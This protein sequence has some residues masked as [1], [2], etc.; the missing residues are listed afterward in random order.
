M[1]SRCGSFSFFRVYNDV[2][3]VFGNT[4]FYPFRAI[5]DFLLL[6]LHKEILAAGSVYRVT[7]TWT[8][9]PDTESAEC[10]VCGKT[11][12]KLAQF[13]QLAS[14]YR[15]AVMPKRPKRPRDLILRPAT[16]PNPIRTKARTRRPSNL[17]RRG[18]LAHYRFSKK[19]DSHIHALA[20]YFVWYNFCRIHKTLRVTPAM[21]AGVSDTVMDMADIVRLT[22]DYDRSK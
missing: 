17:G 7:F 6:W 11:I 20:L 21:A 2:P 8:P 12:R 5:S 19:V 14:T 3:R 18:G 9:I 13:G 4:R 22:D 10:E 15:E 1:V 16:R